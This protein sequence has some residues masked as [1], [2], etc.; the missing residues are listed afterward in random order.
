MY[1]GNPTCNSQENVELVWNS[2]YIGVWH[3]NQEFGNA[4]DSTSNNLDGYPMNSPTP[5]V[6]CKIG[7]GVDFKNYSGNERFDVFGKSVLDVTDITISA[8]CYVKDNDNYVTIASRHNGWQFDTED[9]PI[10]N[11]NWWSSSNSVDITGSQVSQNVW[12]HLVATIDDSSDTTNLYIDGVLDATNSGSV[13]HVDTGGTLYLGDWNGDSS[14]QDWA[15]FLDEIRIMDVALNNSWIETEFNNQNNSNTFYSVGNEET[16]QIEN[17]SP[18]VNFTYEPLSPTTDD[19]IYFNSTSYDPDGYIVNWTWDFGDGNYS[20]LEN[21]THQ[22]TVAGLYSVNLTVID[23][24]SL[25]GYVEKDVLVSPSF[26]S[27]EVRLN[28]TGPNGVNDFIVFG[29]L[30]TASDGQDSY[31]VPKPPTPGEPYIYSWFDAG[32]IVPYNVL[33]KDYRSYPDT[34]K[35]WDMYVRW[36]DSGSGNITIYW[37]SS[38]VNDSEYYYVTLKDVTTGSTTDMLIGSNYTYFA[39]DGVIR[40]FQIIC[41]IEPLE[42]KLNVPLGEEWNLVS[43]SVNKS[44][45]KENF[46]VNYLGVNY[47][48]Q[49]AVDNSTILDFIYGWNATNQNYV[50]TNT[51]KPGDGY[52]MYAYSDCTLWI[53]SNTSNNDDY[54]TG[55]LE[56]WNL[57]GLP[58]DTSVD[59]GNLTVNYNGTNYTWLQA[60]DNGTILGFIYGWNTTSQNYI[61]TDI[62]IPGYGYWMYAYHNC[63]LK[64]LS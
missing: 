26:I 62:L 50:S 20:Y 40:Y 7:K 1:Y 56:E 31:D 22:Y 15:G 49:Q 46:T 32:L 36:E 34:Y 10:N 6:D 18:H 53:T 45:H 57:V 44:V 5:N 27:W 51:L 42:Y 48:W 25:Y 2:H 8:W 59:K 19:I 64:K 12:H 55:L 39:S 37:N 23:N 3:L 60:V 28:F 33:M 58:Y 13:T 4:V 47:T 30:S 14:A 21:A 35:V 54:I 16:H 41:S 29:E 17:Q 61:S 11:I 38:S 9:N 63:T 43:L 52:W 24:D